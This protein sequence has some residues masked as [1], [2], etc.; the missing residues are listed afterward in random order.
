MIMSTRWRI[1]VFLLSA[2]VVA[3][4]PA[5]AGSK[6]KYNRK[7]N[8]LIA[9]RY[10]NRV[11]EID[12]VTG[13]VAWEYTASIKKGST[14]WVVGP[15]DAER[16]GGRTL[17]VAAGLP[18]GVSE[19]YPDGFVDNRV[20]QVAKKGKIKWQYGQKGVAGGGENELDH[21]VAAMLLR[22]KEVLIT[23]QGN[24]RVIQVD[25][26]G[27]IVWQYGTTGVSGSGSNELN[28]PASAQR[29]GNGN[30]VIA[31]AGNDRVIEVTRKGQLVWQYGEPGDTNILSGPTYA[32]KLP[33]GPSFLITDSLNNRVLII[34][35]DGS[36]LFTYATSDRDGSVADPQPTHAVLL[37]KTRNILI[38]D[39]FNHQVI[40]VDPTG[41][42]VNAYGLVGLAGDEEG[43]LD[44][45]TDAKAVGD[46][47]G[48]SAPKGTDS[49]TGYGWF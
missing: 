26:K 25:R 8:W 6:A 31:D 42:V 35:G 38:A 4:W 36:N 37:K 23:D 39:Q 22:K 3:T 13:T 44:A 32:C 16:V 14:N 47:T 12:P 43:A 20:L 45:P 2:L 18:P 30:Y 48:L 19:D 41:A 34:D 24:H 27:R 17:V 10:N 9:D 21:P 46:Y 11:V 40:E 33:G 5:V 7:G 49:D 15:C 29:R 1:P 28:R